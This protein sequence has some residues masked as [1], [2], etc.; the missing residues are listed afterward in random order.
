MTEGPHDKVTKLLDSPA[1]LETEL[2][3]V[4][5]SIENAVQASDRRLRVEKLICMSQE[6]LAK[7]VAKNDQF[8][9][10]AD[11]TSNT[12]TLKNRLEDWLKAVTVKK[13][14]FISQ[15]RQYL[16]I[17]RPKNIQSGTPSQSGHKTACSRTKTASRTPG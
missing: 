12:A 3:K 10:L 7:A 17:F 1:K 13:D 11:E 4:H 5:A 2:N 16:D 15:A 6:D 14:E 8:F 9:A